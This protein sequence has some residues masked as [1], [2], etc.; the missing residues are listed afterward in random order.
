MGM[1]QMVMNRGGRGRGRGGFRPYWGTWNGQDH[2]E[3]NCCDEE[4]PLDDNEW[5]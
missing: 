4:A 5:Q 3:M 1:L 2:R